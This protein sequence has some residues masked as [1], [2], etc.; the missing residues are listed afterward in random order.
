MHRFACEENKDSTRK[1]R[2]LE[3]QS[4]ASAV[5]VSNKYLEIIHKIK[6]NTY[7]KS[8]QVK[9]PNTKQ[10]ILEQ[11]DSTDF[12]EKLRI[13]PMDH[14]YATIIRREW[15]VEPMGRQQVTTE[16]L[17]NS[18]TQNKSPHVIKIKAEAVIKIKAEKLLQRKSPS[19]KHYN[20]YCY[21]RQVMWRSVIQQFNRRESML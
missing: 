20:Y 11:I 4:W 21:P 18:I 7:I 2:G 1:K 17:T 12:S 3:D 6:E 8:Y 16:I 5:A 14:Q 9:C 19:Q 13:R 10:C 15:T